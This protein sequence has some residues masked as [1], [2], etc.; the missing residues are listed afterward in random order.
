MLPAP[1]PSKLFFIIGTLSFINTMFELS[2]HPFGP[3]ELIRIS[4]E[5]KGL[6]YDLIPA[7]GATLNDARIRKGNKEVSVIEGY[8]SPAEME[9]HRHPHG[10][11]SALLLPYP[12]RI[13]N[14]R[15]QFGG[16]SY[17]LERNFPGEPHSIHGFMENAPFGVKG[18]YNGEK[19]LIVE[20]EHAYNGHIK[21]YPWP[22][23]VRLIMQFAPFSGFS[24]KTIVENTG[25]TTLPLGLGWHHYF[26]TG[27]PASKLMLQ[28]MADRRIK[29]DS[30]HIPTGE[31]REYRDFN[32]LKEIGSEPLAHC[33]SLLPTE[34][35]AETLIFDREQDLRISVWQDTGPGKFNYL[36]LYTPQG[37]GSLA[38]EPMTCPANAFNTGDSVIRLAPGQKTDMSM[39]FIAQ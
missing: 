15:Y 30:E 38:V 27:S 1:L 5:R 20:L 9:A 13:E 34:L 29:L 28:F 10:Y 36:Q 19:G 6:A 33:F 3:Y 22:F 25:S 35:R 31:T 18:T 32:R 16:E 2:S 14:G 8:A 11:R 37:G 4:D 24:V 39:G 12:G 26:R 17:G 23:T 7:F 21:A